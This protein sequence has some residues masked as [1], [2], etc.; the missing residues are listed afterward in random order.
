MSGVGTLSDALRRRRAGLRG[1]GGVGGGLETAQRRRG[2]CLGVGGVPHQLDG[3]GRFGA[4]TSFRP[5]PKYWGG[6]VPQQAIE[7][8]PHF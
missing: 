7:A 4:G 1:V 8:C 2:V 5:A 6:E 3:G